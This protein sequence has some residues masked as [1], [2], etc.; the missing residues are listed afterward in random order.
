MITASIVSHGH[1]DLVDRLIGDLVR[2]A[3]PGLT[4]LVLTLNLPEPEPPCLAAAPFQ[5]HVRRNTAPLG[6]AANHNRAFAACTTPWFAIL[7]PDLRLDT[8]VF[9]S[10][11]DAAGPRDALLAPRVVEVD[12]TFAD[13]IRRLPTPWQLMIRLLGRREPAPLAQADWLA[14]MCL[15]ARSEA[16]AAVGGFDQR[17]RLYCED[18]DLCLRLRLAG[19]RMRLVP[20]AVVEHA[21][22]R[23]SRRSLRHL[24][25]HVSSLLRLWTSTAFWRYLAA[26]K[27]M[28]AVG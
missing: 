6:F 23:A 12:G 13:A 1:G 3:S 2:C 22:Q 7:N 8:D 4:H 11:V 18:V 25:W 26:R 14:G 28:A 5:V 27:E 21:A 16:F 10:M 15:L 24:H 19:W 17:Y 9:S 20:E